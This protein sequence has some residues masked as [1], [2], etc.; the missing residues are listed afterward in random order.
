[1]TLLTA[2]I[3]SCHHMISY[4]SYDWSGCNCLWLESM[5][6][7]HLFLVSQNWMGQL[8]QLQ[9]SWYV[10]IIWWSK[11][12]TMMSNVP[13]NP[14]SVIFF[15]FQPGMKNLRRVSRVNYVLVSRVLRANPVGPVPWQPWH[16][17][18][19]TCWIL[20]GRFLWSWLCFRGF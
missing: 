10:D 3:T 1:M 15:S 12:K 2:H 5:F 19:A 17:R 13:L 16:R 8:Q 4:D 14:Y 18:Q 9:A 11:V 6:I 20:R 7:S